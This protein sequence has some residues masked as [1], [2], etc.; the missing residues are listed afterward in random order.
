[1]RLLFKKKKKKKNCYQ[2][3]STKLHFVPS[4]AMTAL[5]QHAKG[6]SMGTEEGYNKWK[7]GTLQLEYTA[8]METDRV[9]EVIAG[10]VPM[11]Q[12]TPQHPPFGLYTEQLSG[13]SFTTPRVKNRRNWTYR[14]LPAVKHTKFQALRTQNKL[15]INDFSTQFK[16]PLQCRWDPLEISSKKTKFY[17][18]KYFYYCC[19][20]FFHFISIFYSF[21]FCSVCVVSKTL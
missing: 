19:F 10:A 11:T 1:M 17:Q 21:C 20:L 13:T 2:I 6:F 9:S 8:G 3:F 18:A 15:L 12:N 4:D 7:K 5:V 14:V 16:H